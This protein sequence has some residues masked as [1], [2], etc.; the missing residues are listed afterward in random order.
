M[1]EKI[2]IS[3]THRLSHLR[4]GGWGEQHLK[5]AVGGM[6]F[7]QS[8]SQKVVNTSEIQSLAQGYVGALFKNPPEQFRTEDGLLEAKLQRSQIDGVLP[9]DTFTV[10]D[11]AA[12]RRSL[13]LRK[14]CGA[15][16]VVAD[17]LFVTDACDCHW[18]VAFNARIMHT[19]AADSPPPA[20]SMRTLAGTLSTFASC[21]R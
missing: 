10:E 3:S 16:G 14:T 1:Q 2:V 8:G 19:N 15:D 20:R 11:V 4:A 17:M 9:G 7:L 5:G 6:P 18:T 12:A 21:E 13:K